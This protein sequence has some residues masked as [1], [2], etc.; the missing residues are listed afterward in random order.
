MYTRYKKVQRIYIKFL[1]KTV[2]SRQ[3]VGQTLLLRAS[4]MKKDLSG[5]CSS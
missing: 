5:F 3:H 1:V 2:A 4:T